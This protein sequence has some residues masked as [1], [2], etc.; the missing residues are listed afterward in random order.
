MASSTA[1]GFWLVA[2]FVEVDERPAMNPL[3]Q[4]REVP[5]NSIYIECRRGWL[6]PRRNSHVSHSAHTIS[7]VLW[8]V[9]K[10]AEKR[11]SSKVT[12]ASTL[13]RS[14]ISWANAWISTRRAASS[15]MPRERR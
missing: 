1:C 4:E 2:A 7:L 6:Q 8:F 15:S 11:S 5:P 9:E 14:I 10:W 13:M 12:R 3:P